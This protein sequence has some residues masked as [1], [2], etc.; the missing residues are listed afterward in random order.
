MQTHKAT[1]TL[2]VNP[3]GPS[4]IVFSPDGGALPDATVGQAVSELVT[5]VSG[6]TPPYAFS[7]TAGTLPPGLSLDSNLNLTGT[8]TTA[9]DFTFEITATD[10]GA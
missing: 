9:G 6:G 2:H 4:P 5:Q 7:V 8:P 3:A 1:F 10:S